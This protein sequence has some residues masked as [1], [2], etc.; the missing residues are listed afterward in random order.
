MSEAQERM[1]AVDKPYSEE[2]VYTRSED[3]IPLEGAVIRP[4]G[5]PDRDVA[6]VW[7]HGLTG[8]FYSP[9]TINVGRALAGRGFTF[10]TG[11][12]RGHDFG[13]VVTPVGG[14]RTIIGGGWEMFDH[15]PRDVAA[16]IDVAMGLGVRG[17]ALLGHSLGARKVAYYQ[18]Q[19]QDPRVL[20]LVAAS[21]PMRNV[22]PD[23][24][25]L[26]QAERMVADGRGRDLLPWDS[27]PAGAGTM[28]AGSYVNRARVGIDVYGVAAP[29]PPVSRIACPILAIYGT[30]EPT[31]GTAADL[32]TIRRNARAAVRVDTRMFEGADHSYAGH[33][34][35][36]AAT[37]AE[38][39]STL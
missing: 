24:A 30:D 20:G 25:L 2:L 16:W 14:A 38:W 34:A 21:A 26:A 19:R 18:A 22:T 37:V 23:P 3:G 17:V 31:V 32:E 35:E 28:S 11:N 1:R 29:D 36:V 33:E 9:T 7:T 8:R 5:G 27:T 12:N 6:V 13:T 4:A 15:S 10:V 39:A